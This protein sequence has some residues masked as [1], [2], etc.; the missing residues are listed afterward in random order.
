MT[1]GQGTAEGRSCHT[2]SPPVEACPSK[3]ALDLLHVLDSTLELVCPDPTGV[4]RP[5]I[6]NL[7][8]RWMWPR[9]RDRLFGPGVAGTSPTA[10][11]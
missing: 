1:A 8:W 9:S 7:S 4:L 2:L 3:A 10:R 6:S 5:L 11:M